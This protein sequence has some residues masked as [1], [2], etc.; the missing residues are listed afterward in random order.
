MIGFIIICQTKLRKKR[1]SSCMR[2]MRQSTALKLW[3]STVSHP[4]FILTGLVHQKQH[5]H[6]HLLQL[7]LTPQ[8]T[9]LA[10]VIC[11]GIQLWL[12]SSVKLLPIWTTFQRKA[13]IYW[14]IGRYVCTDLCVK[15][16]LNRMHLV[17][18]ESPSLPYHISAGH[19]HHSYFRLCCALWMCILLGKGE[20]HTL[21]ELDI[22]Q[23]HGSTA[24]AEVFIE[25]WY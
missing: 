15:S 3:F 16:K 24:S 4:S 21:S 6:Q 5:K 20:Y 13:L 17:I 23:A 2:Y 22:S 14:G 11:T 1:K 18:G 10:L 19:G 12:H 25:A 9:F 8:L 7:M